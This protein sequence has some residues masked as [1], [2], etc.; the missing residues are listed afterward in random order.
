MGLILLGLLI[1]FLFLEVG[2]RI[3]KRD[4]AFQPDPK[5][6]RSLRP[7][8]ER[9]IYSFDT[10]EILKNLPEQLSQKPSYIG[11][12]Y[13]NNIGF[14]MK[15]NIGPKKEGEK[16]ILFL[17]DSF[18][19]ADGVPNDE[20][21]YYLTQELFSAGGK[22]SWRILNGAIQNGSPVQYILQLREYLK[23]V[24]PDAVIVFFAPNDLTDD[25]NFENQYGFVFNERG[26]PGKPRSRAKLWILQKSW[27]LRYLDV[28]ANRV[29][30]P[31]HKLIWPE[32][33]S[34][35]IP[36]DWVK[37]LCG[38]DKTADEWFNKKTGRY[39]VEMKKMANDSGAEFGIFMIN[40][41]HIFDN[42][43]IYKKQV[44]TI[45]LDN[46]IKGECLGN[47][48]Q[49]YRDFIYKF[50]KDNEIWFKDSY[51]A[52]VSE[53]IKEPRKK[54]WYYY[55]Y[56]FS[57]AGHSVIADKLTEFLSEKIR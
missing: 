44:N 40:Y 41:M 37:F 31:L 36:S 49:S 34:G 13:T 35:Q 11:M 18:T 7:D 12:D 8:V 56:H 21:F 17:G 30:G 25:F 55:D 50:L 19:E 33:L 43:P 4:I 52:L 22:N 5:L 14:R 51:D 39:L 16:R 32:Y 54:L 27:A 15:D 20:R 26:F 45:N 46:A 6:I 42:E 1:S 23:I 29:S 28:F 3:L 48:G 47:K 57:P 53:K 38:R 24:K 10:P 2:V 9:K